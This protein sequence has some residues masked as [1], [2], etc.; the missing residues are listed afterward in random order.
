MKKYQC[1]DNNKPVVRTT[2]I[3]EASNTGQNIYASDNNRRSAAS[4]LGWHCL[5]ISHKRM[6][7]LY[8]HYR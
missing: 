6:I 8:G 4:E 7:D 5:P 1:N 2:R 3:L